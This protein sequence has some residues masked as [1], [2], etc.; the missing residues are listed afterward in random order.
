MA[1]HV[2]PPAAAPDPA[3]WHACRPYL[4]GLDLFNQGYYWE[5]H[6]A[7]ESLWHAAGRGGLLG[8]F[9]KGLIKLAAAGVK[10]REGRPA[11]ASRH[12][13][14]AEELFT[15]TAEKLKAEAGE[16][17]TTNETRLMG[18]LVDE[19]IKIAHRVAESP[20][21]ISPR[22]PVPPVEIVFDFHLLPTA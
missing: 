18:L 11:G 15:T 13:T 14:R 7:W 1:G 8:D 21:H 6:E 3:H 4:Y 22:N 16:S 2:P 17:P 20:P 10:A 5:A 9:L 12:A 19:L